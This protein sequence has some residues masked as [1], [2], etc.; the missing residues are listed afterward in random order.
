MGQVKQQPRPPPQAESNGGGEGQEDN[1]IILQLAPHIVA[2]LPGLWAS[3]VGGGGGGGG[4]GGA[5]GQDGGGEDGA[6]MLDLRN[7]VM[8]V[9]IALL[10]RVGPRV[11]Q[12]G[13]YMSARRLLVS[14]LCRSI[15]RC[16]DNAQGYHPVLLP[17]LDAATDVRRPES[18]SLL[19]VGGWW[20]CNVMHGAKGISFS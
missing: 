5:D 18:L 7:G 20:R 2:P 15:Q 12:V 9:L 1:D 10:P 3:A 8:G 14:L 17:M 13:M 4:S 16:H 6:I 19:E 11:A